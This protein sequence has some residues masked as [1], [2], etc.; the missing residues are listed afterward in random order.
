MMA[1]GE[2]ATCVA[3]CQV[4]Q[5]KFLQALAFAKAGIFILTNKYAYYFVCLYTFQ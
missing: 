1:W 3:V 5:R 4:F 2:E